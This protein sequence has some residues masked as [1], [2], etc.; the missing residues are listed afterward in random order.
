MCS[1]ESNIGLLLPISEDRPKP[2]P[3]RLD[4]YEAVI[5]LFDPSREKKKA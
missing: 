2:E 4:I 1:I 3:P 5:V